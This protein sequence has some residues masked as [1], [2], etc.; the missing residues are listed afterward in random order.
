MKNTACT[1]RPKATKGV[2]IKVF[3]KA[4]VFPHKEIFLPAGKG[5]KSKESL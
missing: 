4:N 3:E 2:K 5:K 1:E